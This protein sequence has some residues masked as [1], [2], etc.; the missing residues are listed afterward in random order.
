MITYPCFQLEA[1][2]TEPS[3]WELFTVSHE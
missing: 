1:E 2:H 3:Y